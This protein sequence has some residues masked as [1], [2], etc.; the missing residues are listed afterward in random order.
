[1]TRTSSPVRAVVVGAGAVASGSHLPALTA[2]RD[3]VTV[4]AIVDVRSERVE[5]AADSWG[6]PRRYHE[7]DRMLGEVAPEIAVVC[8]P[9]AAHRG[10]AAAALEASALGVVYEA[11]RVRRDR[12]LRR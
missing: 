7:L 8:T 11:S 9:P 3:R 2:L 4:E 1:V 10:S 6:I 5:R 12:S